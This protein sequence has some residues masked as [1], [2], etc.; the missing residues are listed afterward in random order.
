MANAELNFQALLEPKLRI[1]FFESYAEKP[2]EYV[3]IYRVKDSKKAKETDQHVAGLSAWEKKDPQGSIKYE[4]INLGD[5]VEYIHEE[6]AKGIGIER[7]LVDDEMYDV[8]NKLPKSLGKG[9]RVIVETTA[10]QVL[11]DAFIVDGYDGV[12]LFSDA[13]PLAGFNG[14]TCDNKITTALSDPGIHEARLLMRRQ[15]DEAGLKIQANPDTII[16]PDDL[17][18]KLLTLLQ[19]ERLVGTDFNDKSLVY[20]KYRPVV[21]SYLDD[22]NNWF[23]QDSSLHEMTFFWR[24]KPEFKGEENFDTMI[25][26]YRGYLRFSCGYSDWRGMVGA[27]VT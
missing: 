11:N 27:D 5:D 16:V 13:H 10:A 18:I 14:G 15:V 25:A 26:K 17:E 24:I 6:Y 3:D 7:R 8:I 21:M 2:P 23:M 19:T 20:G 9:G 22:P 1:V 4:N 12:P